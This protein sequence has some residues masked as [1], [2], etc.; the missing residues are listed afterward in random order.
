[1][2]ESFPWYAWERV[3]HFPLL[4]LLILIFHRHLEL[5]QQASAQQPFGRIPGFVLVLQDSVYS[6][7]TGGC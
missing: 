7:G 5:I 6:C 1:M 4:R 3:E 2:V